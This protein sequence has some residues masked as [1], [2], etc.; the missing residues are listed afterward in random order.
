MRYI[1]RLF[2]CFHEERSLF[3]APFTVGQREELMKG[4]L[5]GGR[6]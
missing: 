6:L 1:S 2:R 5:P 3:E 4:R